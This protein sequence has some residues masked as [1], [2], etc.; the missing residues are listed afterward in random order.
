MG[1]DKKR[2]DKEKR[3]PKKRAKKINKFYIVGM[4][5]FSIL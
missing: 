3:P 1:E 5:I 2:V 4:S